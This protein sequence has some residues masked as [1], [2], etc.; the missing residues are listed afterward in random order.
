M[1]IVERFDNQILEEEN[2]MITHSDGVKVAARIW[3][4][5]DSDENPVPVI[6]EVLPYRKRDGTAV[7]DHLTHPYFAGHGYACVRVDQR[8]NGE[9]E[10]LMWAASTDC[11]SPCANPKA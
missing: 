9:S 3:R 8:G 10:G 4:P 2:V 6:L 5:H 7:R 1:K 11:R